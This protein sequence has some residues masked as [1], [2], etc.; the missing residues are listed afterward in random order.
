LKLRGYGVTLPEASA[1]WKTHK[2]A[3]S[4]H[5]TNTDIERLR[6]AAK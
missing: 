5:Y 4:H 1:Y 2:A 3:A 6:A